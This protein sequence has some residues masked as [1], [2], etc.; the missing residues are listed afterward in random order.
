MLVFQTNPMG[1]AGQVSE[2]VPFEPKEWTLGR[3]KIGKRKQGCLFGGEQQIVSGNSKK[4]V[5]DNKLLQK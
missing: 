2:S 1:H 4:T 5:R 3:G